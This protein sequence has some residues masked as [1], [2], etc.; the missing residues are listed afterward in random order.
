MS[1]PP[2]TL[3]LQSHPPQSISP[4]QHLPQIIRPQCLWVEVLGRSHR[5]LD[6]RRLS[7]EL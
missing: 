4:D 5:V 1:H 2:L 3:A 7:K 6:R